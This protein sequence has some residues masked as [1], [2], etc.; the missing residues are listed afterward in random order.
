M[1]TPQ[2]IK[3]IS[4]MGQENFKHAIWHTQIEGSCTHWVLLLLIFEKI[5]K[6]GIPD[7]KPKN[8]IIIA[9]R[10]RKAIKELFH[11]FDSTLIRCYFPIIYAC[12]YS[13]VSCTRLQVALCNYC[14]VL[15]IKN[16]SSLDL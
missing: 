8:N 15:P 16:T 3:I 14:F 6:N 4:Q 9:R 1:H 13:I 2:E 5:K 7:E 11:P 10:S 12:A